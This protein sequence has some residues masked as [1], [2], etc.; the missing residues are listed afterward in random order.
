LDA[1]TYQVTYQLKILTT[2]LFSVAM[3]PGARERMTR[4]RWIGLLILTL[5]V[6]LAQ[7]STTTGDEVRKR[8]EDGEGKDRVTWEGWR[9]TQERGNRDNNADDQH[10]KHGNH[11]TILTH[12]P[13]PFPTFPSSLPSIPTK[14]FEVKHYK[15]PHNRFNLCNNRILHFRFRRRIFRDGLK[16]Q[17]NRPLGP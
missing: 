3:I 10:M 5:G 9:R 16:R 11:A 15:G 1:T 2:A 8:R 7:S 6:C 4:Q 12:A 14:G 17:Q 13:Q